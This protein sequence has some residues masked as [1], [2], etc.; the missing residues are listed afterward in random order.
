MKLAL[1][2]IAVSRPEGSTGVYLPIHPGAVRHS[3]S[4]A[5]IDHA[6]VIQDVFT[7]FGLVRNKHGVVCI[8]RHDSVSVELIRNRAV[9][10]NICTS[11]SLLANLKD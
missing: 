2:W 6:T 9:M 11:L 7:P 8:E 1:C 3:S 4:G 10:Y 5:L